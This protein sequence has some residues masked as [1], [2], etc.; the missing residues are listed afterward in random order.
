M[1]G[2][3]RSTHAGPYNWLPWGAEFPRR[4]KDLRRRELRLL[5]LA[6]GPYRFVPASF[7]S[8]L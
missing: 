6:D 5:G 8:R 3:A 4:G 1:V 2:P 7:G